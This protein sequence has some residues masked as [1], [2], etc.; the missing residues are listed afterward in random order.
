MA[1]TLILLALVGLLG[2]ALEFTHRRTGRSWHPGTDSRNDR[3]FARMQQELTAVAQRDPAPAAPTEPRRQ[4]RTESQPSR[5]GLHPWVE[6]SAG[7]LALG[8]RGRGR[9]RVTGGA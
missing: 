7:R 4:P 1:G 5:R 6:P 3:D 9:G 8:D 2:A